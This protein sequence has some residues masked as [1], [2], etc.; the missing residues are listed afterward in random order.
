MVLFFLFLL[1]IEEALPPLDGDLVQRDAV[2]TGPEK[3]K[4]TDTLQMQPSGQLSSLTGTALTT[5]YI[6]VC[7]KKIRNACA[8]ILS[9]YKSRGCSNS[10]NFRDSRFLVSS[11][12]LV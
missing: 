8:L 6:F 1:P 5:E 3:C 4:D 9:L 12:A 7:E 10:V 11:S 2:V